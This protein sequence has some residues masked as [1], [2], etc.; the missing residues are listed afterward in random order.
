MILIKIN[1]LFN[2][3][4]FLIIYP[5]VKIKKVAQVPRTLLI[6]R[7]DAI[8]D[9][10]LFRN[11]ITIL[12]E[13]SKYKNCK[14]TLCGNIVWKE[15]AENLDKDL[16]DNFIWIDRKKF[17]RNLLYK[18]KMLKKIHN[19]G[20]E[21]AIET[22]YSREI[23]FGDEIIKST[24][25]KEKIGNTGSPDKHAK[26]KRNLLSDKWYTK[27]I[28]SG[29]SNLFEF[30][31]NKEFFQN[32]LEAEINIKR[33]LID[34]SKISF[35]KLHNKNYIVLLPGGSSKERRWN[36]NNFLEIAHY[37][38]N[39]STFDIVIDGSKNEV[40][41]AQKIWDNLKSERIFIAAGTTSLSDMA[42]LISGAKL[43]ISNETSAVHFAAAVDTKFIC[44]SNGAYY[45]RFHPYPE[46]IFSGAFYVYPHELPEDS[47][48]DTG[49]YRFGS[50]L[51]INTIKPEEVKELIN[52][53]IN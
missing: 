5:F 46:E 10:V 24:V 3:L 52:K 14:I 49:K 50:R 9:Y 35:N 1:N 23:L 6:V 36:V 26:W 40:E 37:I 19:Y 31:R 21:I 32:L 7:L 8:G 28:P 48:L 33:P 13:S 39:N 53:L 11:F 20:F 22:T 47:K 34:V 25:A 44:I 15:L 41:L 18:Y 27:L 16:I 51:D 12:K 4:L 30:Y 42:K 38:L 2:F 45:N 17:Y 29:E 43:L